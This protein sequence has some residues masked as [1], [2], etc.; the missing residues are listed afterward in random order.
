MSILRKAS[1]VTELYVAH[2]NQPQQESNSNSRASGS[3][4]KP[5]FKSTT[6]RW[7][8]T[9]TSD[10]SDEEPTSEQAS[11]EDEGLYDVT[12]RA[13]D[14]TQSFLTGTSGDRV[15]QVEIEVDGLIQSFREGVDE[16]THGSG[17][18]EASSSRAIW[19]MLAFALESVDSKDGQSGG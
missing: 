2:L 12:I 14:T 10:T 7:R 1:T 5:K 19:G 4:E 11:G 6:R 13:A 15:R 9:A 3:Q 18:S 17:E 8:R 16:L